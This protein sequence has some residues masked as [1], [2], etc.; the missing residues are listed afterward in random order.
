MFVKMV[1]DS[2]QTVW[3]PLTLALSV[4]AEEPLKSSC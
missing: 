1:A 4:P 2:G 3:H